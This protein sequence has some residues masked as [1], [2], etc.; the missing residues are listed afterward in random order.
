M[1][2]FSYQNII[3]GDGFGLTLTGMAIVFVSL[4]LVA[5]AIDQLPR[6]L[7]AFDALTGAGE[8]KP[9]TPLAGI[10]DPKSVDSESDAELMT[11]IGLVI[12]M[13]FEL[14]S[15]EDKQKITI[16]RHVDK[17]SSWAAAGKMKTFSRREKYAQV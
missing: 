16:S 6:A 15:V 2:Q 9:T 5:G 11:A 14:A 17:R 1:N 8:Q 13:E 4:T 7:R 10:T 3:A 12:H